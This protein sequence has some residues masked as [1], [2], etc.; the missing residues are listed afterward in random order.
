M[1]RVSWGFIPPI[2]KISV[3]IL[4]FK[5]IVKGIVDNLACIIF[6]Q[7]DYFIYV[8]FFGEICFEYLIKGKS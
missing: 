3:S 5:K 7:K 2:A 8:L 1:C 4:G 6:P